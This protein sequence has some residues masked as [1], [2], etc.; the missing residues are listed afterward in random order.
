MDFFMIFVV[1]AYYTYKKMIFFLKGD[2]NGMEVHINL[3]NVSQ[4]VNENEIRSRIRN[5]RR[6]LSMAQSR[7]NRIEV[8]NF[9]SI[10]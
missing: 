9:F 7:L 8:I 3:G 5:I 10:K 6:F 4:L 2:S 1:V